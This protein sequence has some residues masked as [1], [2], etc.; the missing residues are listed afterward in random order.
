MVV[1]VL[2]HLLY[3][4]MEDGMGVEMKGGLTWSMKCMFMDVLE[5][6]VGYNTGTVVFVVVGGDERPD[7]T[8][9]E[10]WLL[11]VI[12]LVRD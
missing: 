8:E 4:D 9:S 11:A 5:H 6:W 2:L 12:Y 3:L 10:Q 1:Y 7:Q